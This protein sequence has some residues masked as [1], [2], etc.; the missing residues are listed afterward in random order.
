MSPAR[1]SSPCHQRTRAK[2]PR[3]QTGRLRSCGCP[4]PGG[5]YGQ[6]GWA[7]GSLGSGGRNWVGLRVPSH[8]ARSTPYKGQP[9]RGVPGA[10]GCHSPKPHQ[11]QPSRKAEQP[12]DAPAPP[13]PAQRCQQLAFPCSPKRPHLYPHQR[14]V[15]HGRVV[16]EDA[17]V[18]RALHGR[19]DLGAAGRRRVVEH[20][21]QGEHV[22]ELG[23]E[24]SAHRVVRAR[25]ALHAVCGDR[26]VSAACTVLGPP[27]GAG[28]PAWSRA[29]PTEP[30]PALTSLQVGVG[31]VGRQEHGLPGLQ[32]HQVEEVDGE[33]ADVPRELGVQAQQQVPVAPRRVL[34]FGRC[35][36][37]A[38]GLGGGSTQPPHPSLPT[39][40]SPFWPPR[41]S[42]PIPV[43]PSW[44]PRLGLPIPASSVAPPPPSPQYGAFPRP[45]PPSPAPPPCPNEAREVFSRPP[46]REILCTRVLSWSTKHF[47]SLFISRV[48][49]T[50]RAAETPRGSWL[51][52]RSSCSAATSPTS[53]RSSG[54]A[55]PGG[56][57]RQRCHG[58]GLRPLLPPFPKAYPAG[59][60]RSPRRVGS[61]TSPRRG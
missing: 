50:R 1:S 22:D 48:K 60:R 53:A 27:H 18:Q 33:A 2:K 52:L 39:L 4:L 14:E 5:G 34:P 30:C 8:P 21:A 54:T 28:P 17:G 20:L 29:P 51:A 46:S 10:D 15:G 35:G 40:I 6:A 55:A 57:G 44:P 23:G 61:R 56:R 49:Q 24:A 32:P 3:G 7:L 16:E 58:D 19:E 47:F 59:T 11:A 9:G 13:A 42:L 31:L 37:S 45:F 36:G 43:S 38:V 25:H 26:G 41:P 12:R